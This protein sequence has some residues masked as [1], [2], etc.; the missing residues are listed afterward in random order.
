MSNLSEACQISATDV[1]AILA[2]TQA[3]LAQHVATERPIEEAFP[4]VPAYVEPC[5]SHILIQVR[6]PA[7]KTKGGIIRADETKDIERYNQQIGRVVA[8]G[9]LAFKNRETL[10]GWAEGP[11]AQVGD[12]IRFKRHVGDRWRNPL[13]GAKTRDECAWFVMINDLDIVGKFTGDPTAEEL[14]L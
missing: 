4:D 12:F 3:K 5:G 2:K 14:A 13:P 1:K 7:S 10:K 8:T 6:T 11:W 9:P